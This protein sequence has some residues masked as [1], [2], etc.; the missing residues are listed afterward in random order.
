MVEQNET[1]ECQEAADA[2]TQ[3]GTQEKAKQFV[4]TGLEGCLD[5]QES[6]YY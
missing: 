6:K 4:D 1:G 5:D 2:K 3:D